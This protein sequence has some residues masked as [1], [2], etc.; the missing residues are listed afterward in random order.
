ML[1][2]KI[3]AAN[4][5]ILICHLF[6]VLIGKK[7]EDVANAETPRSTSIP[8]DTYS[9]TINLL[10]RIGLK[11]FYPNKLMSMDAMRIQTAKKY[12]ELK[13]V[14]LKFLNDIVMINCSC[15]DQMLYLFLE[16]IAK[17]KNVHI[18]TRH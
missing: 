18:K 15:R 8:K 7:L 14:A 12:S 9:D 1:R 13:D 10:E 17:W 4:I 16:K 11:R 5:V 2:L 6:P 3:Y